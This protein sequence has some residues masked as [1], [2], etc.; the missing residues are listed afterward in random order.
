MRIAVMGA[1]GLGA[2]LGARLAVAG[3]D[4]AFIARGAQLAAIRNRGLTIR[5]PLGDAFLPGA[6]ATDNPAEI[7]PV[8]LVLFTVKL[9]DTEEAARASLPLLASDTRLLTLQ[10]GIDSVD[11]ISRWVPEHQV[12]GGVTYIAASIATPGMVDH[13]GGG[14]RLVVD[15]IGGH[16]VTRDFRQVCERAIGIDFEATESINSVIWEKF[17]GFAAFS[18]ATSLMRTTAGPLVGNAETRAFLRQLLR[19]GAAVAQ[20]AGNAI[21][22]DFVEVSLHF[23]ASIAP[24]TRSSMATDLEWGRRLE[25][26]WISGRIHALGLEYGV[27]TPAHSAAYRGLIQYA[28]GADR[29]QNAR[30]DRRGAAAEL[31]GESA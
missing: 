10:N 26:N 2:Y 24:T 29:R 30:A 3:A 6:V 23:I 5:S 21:A 4:V 1:G 14:R 20:A 22:P 13:T 19:D 31:L 8:D 17:I 15:G 16:V 9:W 18:A 7:G 27:P 28:D 12:V 25:L 11:L